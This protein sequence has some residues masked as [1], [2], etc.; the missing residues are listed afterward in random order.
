MTK[1]NRRE[2]RKKKTI[3]KKDNKNAVIIAVLFIILVGYWAFVQFAEGGTGNYPKYI[4]GAMFPTPVVSADG[5]KVTVPEEFVESNKLVYID[6]KLEE[7]L[8][9]L[10]YQGRRIP[11]NMYGEGEYLPIVIIF[12]PKGKTLSGIRVCEP[13]SSFDFHIV[14]KKYLQCNNCGTRWNIETLQGVSGACMN[15]PPPKLDV[16]TVYDVEVNLHAVG[17]K[18]VS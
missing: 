10:Q 6:L 3:Q 9:E 7:P 1:N 12:T 17:L 14:E 18:V 16:S 5:D 8:D 15:Y 2:K 13:C 11:I 4:E